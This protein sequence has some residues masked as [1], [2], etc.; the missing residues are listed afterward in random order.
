MA[1]GNF[2]A[3]L[4]VT[5]A[6]EGAWSDHPSDPGGATM[7]GITIGRY[8]EHYPNATKEDLRNISA[9]DVQRIYRRDY[10]DQ[11]RG[12]DLPYGLDLVTFDFGVNSG[13]A[14][15][16]RYLQAVLGAAQ[17]GKVDAG[18]IRAATHADG[19]STIQKLCAKRLSFVQALATFKVFGKG[20]S[21]RIADVEAKAVAMWLARGGTLTA[22]DRK[23]LN[24]EAD[25]ASK[26]AA[27][28]S[29]GA[30]T[31]GAVGGGSA[32]MTDFNWLAVVL[33]GGLLIAAAVLIY[34]SSLNKDRA[35]AFAEAA[36]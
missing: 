28:Q 19:K 25:K 34:K 8:R 6:Y 27:N 23:T 31:G 16:A 15:A 18:T 32:I 14:R 33:I 7:K 21:R 22:D 26:T 17:S 11:V 10:W 12:D 20:W 2:S 13:P 1:L 9:A 29:K 35:Q 24:N 5:L 3:C 36:Q 4:P 30:A